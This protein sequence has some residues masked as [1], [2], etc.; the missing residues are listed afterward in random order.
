MSLRELLAADE[1]ANPTGCRVIQWLDNWEG[2]D[3]AYLV[4]LLESSESTDRLRRMFRKGG[5]PAIGATVLNDHR[6]GRC[7][8]PSDAEGKRR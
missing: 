6:Y 7:T 5:L 8:C 1:S 2:D 3:R 4:E